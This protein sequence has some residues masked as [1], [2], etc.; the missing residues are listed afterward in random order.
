MHA[1]ESD[2]VIMACVSLTSSI[3]SRFVVQLFVPLF[4]R[5]NEREDTHAYYNQ[6]DDRGAP[7]F[8]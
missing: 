3:V 2:T 1:W 4:F 7:Y 6:H 5:P 8:F